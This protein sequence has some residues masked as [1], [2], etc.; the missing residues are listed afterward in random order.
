MS[1]GHWGRGESLRMERASA[2]KRCMH[3]LLKRAGRA[4]EERGQAFVEFALLAPLFFMLVIGFIQFAVAL[5][6]WFDLNRLANQGARSAAVNCGPTSGNQCIS[7]TSSKLDHFLAEQI[8]SSGNYL[9]TTDESKTPGFAEVC[10]VPPSDPA[11]SGWTPSAGDAVRVRL[12]DRYRLQAIVNLAKIDLTA[13]ATMRLEQDP[14]AS[15]L[16]DRTNQSNW[17]LAANSASGHC[18][19]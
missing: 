1:P 16:P 18:A 3:A 2:D 17:V 14:T 19:P 12:K 9:I 15:A 6:F 5:N 10:Y 7:G 4:R 8:L 11:P 13:T